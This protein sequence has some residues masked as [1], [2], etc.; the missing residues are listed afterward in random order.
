MNKPFIQEFKKLLQSTY[1]VIMLF[2]FS[3]TAVVGYINNEPVSIYLAVLG[4]YA[5][6]DTLGYKYLLRRLQELKLMYLRSL[7]SFAVY[8]NAANIDLKY[9]QIVA[10]NYEIAKDYDIISVISYRIIQHLFLFFAIFLTG[11]FVDWILAVL[12]FCS[13]LF[14]IADTVFYILAKDFDFIYKQNNVTWISWTPYGLFNKYIFK[15]KTTGLELIIFSIISIT[16]SLILLLD[17][18][19]G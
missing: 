9:K 7:N 18:F 3:L 17:K 8:L 5:V 16:V 10:D 2:V 13:W 12:I 15:R 6:F 14:G 4:L 19:Y 11:Y 1:A